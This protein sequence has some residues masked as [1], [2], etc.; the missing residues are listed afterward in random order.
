MSIQPLPDHVAAQIRSSATVTSLNA[1][2]CGL[3]KNSLDANATKITISLDYARGNCTVEDNGS[4]IAPIEFAAGGGL[5]KPHRTLSYNG[6]TVPYIT[7][8]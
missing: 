6:S 5:G 1:V 4:G 2:A 8:C 3:L 7:P